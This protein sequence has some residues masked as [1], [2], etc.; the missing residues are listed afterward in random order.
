MCRFRTPG[1]PRTRPRPKPAASA[2]GSSC[3]AE[4]M[5]CQR[6][7]GRPTSLMMKSRHIDDGAHRQELAEEHDSP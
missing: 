1:S 4:G 3:R 2:A 6:R 7:S 5:R